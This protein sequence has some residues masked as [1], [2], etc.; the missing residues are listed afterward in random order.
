MASG[1]G[2][3]IDGIAGTA[4]ERS[5]LVPE[6]SSRRWQVLAFVRDY[7]GRMGGSPS[8]REIAAAL[9]TNP[10][11]VKEA[12]RGLV[13]DGHLLSSGQPRGLMLPEDHAAA[14]R[15]LRA[16]GWWVNEALKVALPV[17]DT[18]LPGIPVLDYFPEQDGSGDSGGDIRSSGV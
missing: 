6:M 3:T 5:R 15:T 13:R 17:T 8:Y 9:S 1:Q 14:I 12:I 2:G 4:G 11:R 18:T 16:Q 7:I 10:T